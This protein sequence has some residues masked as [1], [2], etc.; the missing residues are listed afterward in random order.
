[1][2]DLVMGRL[3]S[4]L[5]ALAFFV[6]PPLS[7]HDDAEKDSARPP[8]LRCRRRFPLLYSLQN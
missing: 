4:L 3:S 6:A 1:M 7:L 5:E 8:V 2:F